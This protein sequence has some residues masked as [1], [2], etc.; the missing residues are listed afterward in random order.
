MYYETD[1]NDHGLRYNPLKPHV[2]E[3]VG[4]QDRLQGLAQ[5]HP[6]V[7]EGIRRGEEDL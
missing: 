7:N 5:G 2:Q 1:K 6:S 3:A 4:R